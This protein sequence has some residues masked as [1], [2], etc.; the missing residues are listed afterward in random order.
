M[1]LR[2]YASGS[3]NT[4]RTWIFLCSIYCGFCIPNT[5]TQNAMIYELNHYFVTY[6]F[7]M[8]HFE[9]IFVNNKFWKNLFLSVNLKNIFE[10]MLKRVRGSSHS[11]FHNMYFIAVAKLYSNTICIPLFDLVYFKLFPLVCAV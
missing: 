3:Q 2:L 4:N 7:L 11:A 8:F 1:W 5:W 10:K 6:I 9:C